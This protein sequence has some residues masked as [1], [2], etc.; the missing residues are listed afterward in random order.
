MNRFEDLKR[1]M[2]VL[3]AQMEARG[4]EVFKEG[5]EEIFAENP[6]LVSFR[7]TQYTPYFNDGEPCYFG[8][9]DYLDVKFA[10]GTL[11]EDWDTSSQKYATEYESDYDGTEEQMSTATA[12]AELVSSIPEE[13]LEKIFGDH[14]EVT[15]YRDRIEV[16]EYEH[17]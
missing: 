8:V 2:E 7:W 16:E 13:V 3:M 5:T 4:R 14:A 12:A 9:N 11:L 6:D 1:E 15:V 17:D 10:D